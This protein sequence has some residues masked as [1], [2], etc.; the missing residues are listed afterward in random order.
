MSIGENRD[1][2]VVVTELRWACRLLEVGDRKQVWPSIALAMQKSF[3]ILVFSINLTILINF[4][5]NPSFNY[6]NNSEVS[7]PPL[8]HSLFSTRETAV[9]NI[10]KMFSRFGQLSIV[11]LSITYLR[12]RPAQ[13]GI[14]RHWQKPCF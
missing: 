5:G 1:R 14:R 8:L 6:T 11:L 9:E 2:V 7:S 13:L 4:W 3:K 12:I 10:V